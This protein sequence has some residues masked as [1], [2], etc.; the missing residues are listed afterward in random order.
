M[1]EKYIDFYSLNKQELNKFWDYI[2]LNATSVSFRF[3]NTE[4]STSNTLKL[5]YNDQAEI[6]KTYVQYIEK[7]KIL[8]CQ[9]SNHLI[10]KYISNIYFNDKYK[11][12]SEIYICKI[13]DYLKEMVYKN[14]NIFKWLAPELPEDLSFYK[15]TDKFLYVC[16]HENI[17]KIYVTKEELSDLK[18]IIP[19]I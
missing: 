9:S 6:S 19:N 17:C 12:L 13:F 16:S 1:I 11:N 15:E 4:H 3:P 8:I 18:K 5:K 2:F 7:N 14:P 10:K